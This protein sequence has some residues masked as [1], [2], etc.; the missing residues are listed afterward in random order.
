MSEDVKKELHETLEELSIADLSDVLAF[1]RFRRLQCQTGMKPITA[2]DW[3][4]LTRWQRLH[5]V[6]LARW[7]VFLNQADHAVQRIL[8]RW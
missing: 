5:L 1:A 3:A 7:F 4:L 8:T 2:E 6:L